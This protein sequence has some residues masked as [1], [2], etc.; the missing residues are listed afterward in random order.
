MIRHLD[1]D[2]ED[3]IRRGELTQHDRQSGAN[4]EQGSVQAYKTLVYKD[5][6]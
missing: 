6:V 1:Q 5:G 2:C 4:Q 3:S